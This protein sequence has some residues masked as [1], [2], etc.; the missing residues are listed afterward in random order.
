MHDDA[1]PLDDGALA[2]LA[3]E[4]RASVVSSVNDA[5]CGLAADL[6]AP[7]ESVS[8]RDW[9][10]DFPT[11]IA[12]L[13]RSPYESQADSVMYR[14]VIA[15]TA[16]GR[17]WIVHRFDAR[18]IED[19]AIALLGDADA[20]TSPRDRFGAPWNKDHRMAFAAAIVATTTAD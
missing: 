7:I 14:Q 11:D 5:L 13:R 10:S 17:G 2:D 16:L 20:L 1:G 6:P 9:P 12:T 8:L 18:T 3:A 4:V 19:V 15:E